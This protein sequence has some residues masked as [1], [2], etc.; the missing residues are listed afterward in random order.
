[1]APWMIVVQCISF[2]CEQG[3][4][5]GVNNFATHAKCDRALIAIVEN[6]QPLR[7]G[8]TINCRRWPW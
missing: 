3:P 8:Y 7:G 2:S 6:W 1:M 5:L 4:E